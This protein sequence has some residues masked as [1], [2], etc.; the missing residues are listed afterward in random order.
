MC[1][2]R[3]YCISI[4]PVVF[5]FFSLGSLLRSHPAFFLPLKVISFTLLWFSLVEPFQRWKKLLNKLKK[6]KTKNFLT[7]EKRIE[8]KPRLDFSFWLQTL[9][10][11]EIIANHLQFPELTL[12]RTG[13]TRFEY[14]SLPFESL[15]LTHCHC[16]KQFSHL[17]SKPQFGFLLWLLSRFFSSTLPDI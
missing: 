5:K 8:C 9:I 1:I 15:P 7:W 17:A 12:T 3:G 16:W 10:M 6:T 4:R 14:L 11:I 2:C 13:R